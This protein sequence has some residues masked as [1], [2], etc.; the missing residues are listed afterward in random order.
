M[1]R[2]GRLAGPI[3][4]LSILIL[5]V[6][7]HPASAEE[8]CCG[9]AEND[10]A[11]EEF[12]EKFDEA[13]RMFDALLR[14]IPRYDVP[15]VTEDGDIIIRRLPPPEDE[16]PAPRPPPPTDRGIVQL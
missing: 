7:A 16:P 13:R 1:M 9:P 14:E 10:T 11:A 15:E 5:A 2:P 3:I 8:P 12:W 4:A 6:L